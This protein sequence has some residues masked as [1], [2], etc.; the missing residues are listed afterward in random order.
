MNIV[1]RLLALLK[2]LQKPLVLLSN[3][4]TLTNM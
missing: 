1:M 4:N 3:Q 2:Q